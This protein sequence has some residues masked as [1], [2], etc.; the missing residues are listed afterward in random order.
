MIPR[1]ITKPEQS[2]KTFLMLQEMMALASREQPG[3]N[4]INLVYCDNNLMLV[5]QTLYRVD[6][7]PILNNHIELSS[8]KRADTHNF[9]EVVY[10]IINE[11]TKSV[12]CCSNGVRMKDFA[13]I[14]NT[15]YDL[16]IGGFYN[17]HVWV[18]EGDKWLP[19]I[20]RYI[21]PLVEKYGNIKLNFI[22]AT[23]ERI[24]K[25]FG[26]VE[27][28]PLEYA[29]LPTYHKWTDSDHRSYPD[30]FS[31]P[32]FVEYILAQNAGEIKP[33]TKWFM[34]GSMRKVSH[35]LI[36]EYCSKY[37]FATIIINGDGIKIYMPDGKVHNRERDTMPD[38]LI[39]QIYEEYGLSQFPLAITGYM[40]IAR[41]IT[42]SSPQF[43]ITHAI[44]PAGMTNKQ[45]ISQIAGRTKGNQKDWATYKPPKVYATEKFMGIAHSIEKKTIGISEE[46]FRDGRTIL[47]EDG[48]KSA[49][50]EFRY[51]Q[52]HED[53]KSYQDAV[54]YLESQEQHLKPRGAAR[55]VIDAVK[56]IGRLKNIARRGGTEEGHWVACNTKAKAHRG[57]I[58][59]MTRS[60]LESIPIHKQVAHPQNTK[61][62][63]YIIQPVYESETSHPDDVRFV[64]RHTVWK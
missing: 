52:H 27:V 62:R 30:L 1:L 57:E 47:D 35:L 28:M 55:S 13:K 12:L 19:C 7:F 58:P 10:K 15:L 22:T 9:R 2:G 53:F 56:M 23:S 24:I 39:P 21:M 8:S 26:K 6:Q 60:Q 32:E 38:Q 18:D 49:D 63:S 5:L 11:G 43:Q 48:F 14:L 44:M 25:R 45:E 4:N 64:V 46:A 37:D 29:H 20:D 16:N 54:E 50:L 31:T 61:Y 17:F 3:D 36:K 41:G 59:I 42:I 51:H 40:C 34:P 33:G